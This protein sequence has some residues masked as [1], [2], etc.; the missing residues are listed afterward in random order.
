ME[1]ILPAAIQ[2]IGFDADDT[3][4]MNEPFYKKA[5]AE[6]VELM[7]S[8]APPEEISAT[9]HEINIANLGIYGYGSRSF[10]LSMM[11]TTLKLSG[12]KAASSHIAAILDLGKRLLRRPVELLEDAVPVLEKLSEKYRLILITKGDLHEQEQKL[13]RSSLEHFFHHIE[14]M[15]EKNEVHYQKLLRHLEIA[16]HEF[17]MIGNSLKSD[18][19]PVLNLGGYGIHVPFHTVWAYDHLDQEVTHP[20]YRKLAKLSEILEKSLQP[21]THGR[22]IPDGT[23]V[24]KQ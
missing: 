20:N 8:F 24:P 9:L 1:K 16:P 13:R 3:L 12:G 2:R 6:Y 14:I 22:C 15:S 19:L 21:A 7:R 23:A 10:T 4:W 18:I 5:E 11:E 17:L